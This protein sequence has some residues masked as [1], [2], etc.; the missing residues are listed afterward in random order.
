MHS[1]TSSTHGEPALRLTAESLYLLSTQLENLATHSRDRSDFWE[2]IGGRPAP[3]AT[4]SLP[5]PTPTTP[6][7]EAEEQEAV[8]EYVSEAP[9]RNPPRAT[10]PQEAARPTL[11]GSKHKRPADDET[12]GDKHVAKRSRVGQLTRPA[13][14]TEDK[15]QKELEE[16][17]Y[18][19]PL[20]PNKELVIQAILS[21]PHQRMTVEEINRFFRVVHPWHAWQ[22]RT[23]SLNAKILKALRPLKPDFMAFEQVPE[24]PDYWRLTATYRDYLGSLRVAD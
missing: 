3:P 5:D 10:K 2:V 20:L 9:R 7:V 21:T 16:C 13:I 11:P 1:R 23:R 24:Q 18:E 4:P 12:P 15:P 8:K 19:R 17:P 22:R 6:Q 14:R